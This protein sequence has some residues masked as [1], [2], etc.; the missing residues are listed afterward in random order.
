MEWEGSY[1]EWLP[2]R[3][4]SGQLEWSGLGLWEPGLYQQKWEGGKR[5]SIQPSSVFFLCAS[6]HLVF[7]ENMCT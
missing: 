2:R 4:F 5:I 1:L 6:M 7:G 3:S